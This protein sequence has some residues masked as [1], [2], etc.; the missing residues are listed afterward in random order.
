MFATRQIDYVKGRIIFLMFLR[1][2]IVD[3][4][5]PGVPLETKLENKLLYWNIIGI[6]ILPDYKIAIVNAN[7]VWLLLIKYPEIIL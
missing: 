5:N 2:I 3:I 7:L 1:I 4:K 6:I